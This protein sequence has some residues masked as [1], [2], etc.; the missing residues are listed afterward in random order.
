M[1]LNFRMRVNS[2]GGDFHVGI[3]PEWDDKATRTLKRENGRSM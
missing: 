3:D 1:E 2:P